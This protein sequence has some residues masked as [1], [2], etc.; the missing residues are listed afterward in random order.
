MIFAALLP[1]LGTIGSKIANSLFPDPEDELKRAEIEN[2]IRA[3]VL[4]NA[5]E[6]EKAAASIINTEAASKHWLAA[7][8]RPVTMLVFVGLIVSRW[9][10]YSAEGMTEAEYLEV[11]NLIKIGLGGY[12]VGRSAE[13]VLPGIISALKK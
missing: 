5:A 8:W 4:N 11:Y 12:V 13:K 1:L 9:L 10:G 7:N 3:T 6:I 2:K